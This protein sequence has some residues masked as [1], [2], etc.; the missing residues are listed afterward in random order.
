MR[1]TRFNHSHLR[2]NIPLPNV[3]IKSKYCIQFYPI[4]ASIWSY[5]LLGNTI[6]CQNSTTN[7]CTPNKKHGS[8]YKTDV[9]GYMHAGVYIHVY[10]LTYICRH[11]Y[12]Q[13]L[14]RSLVLFFKGCR[15]LV[16]LT[17]G[18]LPAPP[19]TILI[20]TWQEASNLNCWVCEGLN[21]GLVRAKHVLRGT[22]AL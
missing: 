20:L 16:T 9:C 5:K 11:T 18:R 15:S 3:A 8:N 4:I 2:E 19:C 12:I 22:S 6:L 1:K 17:K 21:Q 7:Y 13:M 14:S 10:I